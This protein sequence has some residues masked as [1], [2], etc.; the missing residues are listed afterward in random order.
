MKRG[1]YRI[2]TPWEAVH[3]YGRANAEKAFEYYKRHT[4]ATMED[5]NG[6]TLRVA[7]RWT[8]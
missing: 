4:P 2:I 3:V 5:W 8:R 7:S 1:W 6:N